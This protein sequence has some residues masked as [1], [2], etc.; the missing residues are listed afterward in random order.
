MVLARC[1]RPAVTLSLSSW[2]PRLVDDERGSSTQW[3]LSLRDLR[4][5]SAPARE[6]SR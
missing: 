4:A 2:T 3:V 1:A 6:P 5:V